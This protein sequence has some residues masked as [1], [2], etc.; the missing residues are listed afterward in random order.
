MGLQRGTM[1]ESK[2][3]HEFRLLKHGGVSD[4]RKCTR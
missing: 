3:E 1:L 2:K 4:G